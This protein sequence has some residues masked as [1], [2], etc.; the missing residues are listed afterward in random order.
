MRLGEGLAAVVGVVGL[1]ALMGCQPDFSDR[2]RGVEA[3]FD[4]GRGTVTRASG[5][6]TPSGQHNLSVIVDQRYCDA[7]TDELVQRSV[8]AQG[9]S[10]GPDPTV[11]VRVSPDLEEASARLQVEANVVTQRWDGCDADPASEPASEHRGSVEVRAQLEW[12]GTGDLRQDR[13]G[14]DLRDAVAEGVVRVDAPVGKIRLAPSD[15]AQLQAFEG[16]EE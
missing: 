14:V 5:V 15:D 9:Y 2:S 7:S 10:P 11:E 8:Y 6:V 13:S 12:V 3:T 4:D 16:I 1:G